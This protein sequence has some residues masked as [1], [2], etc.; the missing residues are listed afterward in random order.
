MTRSAADPLVASVAALLQ[1]MARDSVAQHIDLPA[2]DEEYWRTVDESVAILVEGVGEYVDLMGVEYARVA[3]AREM[4]TLPAP[5]PDQTLEKTLDQTQEVL[6]KVASL[7]AAT[8]VMIATEPADRVDRSLLNRVIGMRNNVVGQREALRD[9]LQK[10]VDLVEAAHASLA[11]Q[12]VEVENA[13]MY[14]LDQGNEDARRFLVG[15]P[16]KFD[17]DAEP[18]AEDRDQSG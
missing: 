18:T 8:L 17:A 10:L 3:V 2:V 12:G 15:L 5:T 9:E 7:L 1:T 4:R 13:A 6:E 16:P 11:L 14:R